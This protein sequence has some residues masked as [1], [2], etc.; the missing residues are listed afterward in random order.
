MKKTLREKFITASYKKSFRIICTI[1]SLALATLFVIIK[2]YA[3]V[4]VPVILLAFAEAIYHT[5][6]EVVE[7]NKLF[8]VILSYNGFWYYTMLWLIY[9]ICFN[10][11]SNNIISFLVFL[12]FI[13]AMYIFVIPKIAN[14]FKKKLR[15]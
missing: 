3:I 5:E 13:I 1:I 9:A 10:L 14:F 15:K 8:L 11:I 7:N 12:L 4:W 2:L 6:K